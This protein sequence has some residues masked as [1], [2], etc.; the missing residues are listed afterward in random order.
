MGGRPGFQ[1][2]IHGET[3]SAGS[4]EIAQRYSPVT[5]PV[6]MFPSKALIKKAV[7]NRFA[8]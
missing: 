7:A 5:G 1:S 2:N 3:A 6:R 4:A 8:E